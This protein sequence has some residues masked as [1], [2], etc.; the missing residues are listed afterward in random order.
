MATPR[1]ACNR[2]GKRGLAEKM[3]YSRHTGNRYCTDL[4]GCA[5]RAANRRKR[6]AKE[7]NPT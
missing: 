3:V 5:R 1:Y 4:D 6:A 7:T 2:C